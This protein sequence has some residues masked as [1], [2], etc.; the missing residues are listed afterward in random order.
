MKAQ[1]LDVT[2]DYGDESDV[3]FIS[4]GSTEPS[5]SEEVDDLLIVERGMFTHWITGF[6]VLGFK[7]HGVCDV[8]VIEK[9]IEKVFDREKRAMEKQ[10]EQKQRELPN[11]TKAIRNRFRQAKSEDT[12]VT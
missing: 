5:Y 6:R 11:V 12:L 1:N 4:L 3:I 10:F 8:T 7:H 9:K 2:F